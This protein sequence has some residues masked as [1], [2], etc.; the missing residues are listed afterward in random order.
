MR[1]TILTIGTT[2]WVLPFIALGRGLQARGHSVRIAT[3]EPFAEA[4]QRHGLAFS[5]VAGDPRSIIGSRQGQRLL[6]GNPL[7]FGWDLLKVARP[8]ISRGL[9][10]LWAASQGS[11]VLVHNLLVYP[12]ARNIAHSL[13]IPGILA[14]MV[15]A[16][17]SGFLKPVYAP[18]FPWPGSR[19]ERHYNRL[20]PMVSWEIVQHALRPVLS[21]WRRQT[22]GLP[23]TSLLRPFSDLPAP[24]ATLFAYSPA[25]VAAPP[26]WDPRISVTGYWFLEHPFDWQPPREL[27]AFLDDGPPPVYVGFGSMVGGDPRR[28]IGVV[29]DALQR[30]G[31]R[32]LIVSGYGGLVGTEFPETTFLTGDIPFDWLFPRMAALVHHGGS[33]TTALGLRAGLPTVTVPFYG[34]QLLWSSRVEALGI[35]PRPIRQ[36]D[37]TAAG[38]ADAINQAVHDPDMRTR[39][40]DLARRIS[41]EDGVGTAVQIIESVAARHRARGAVEQSADVGA[42]PRQA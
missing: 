26:D 31:Q 11:D 33:G 41:Q 20:A 37:L 30:T 12:A 5:P 35:G 36:K 17:P 16:E 8:L 27:L 23:R 32:A 25:V 14:S 4:I 6:N 40:V 34:D 15:P 3:H 24:A 2:G 7:L 9:D 29:L 13:G 19:A 42:L 39:A 28:E 18:P 1:V 38:L 21:G 22:L 10:D